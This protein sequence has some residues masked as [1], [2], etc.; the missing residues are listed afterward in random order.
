LNI[1]EAIEATAKKQKECRL[2]FA[3][4]LFL[5]ILFIIILPVGGGFSVGHLFENRLAPLFFIIIYIPF[6]LAAL[7]ANASRVTSELGDY[8]AFYKDVFARAAIRGTDSNFNY[9]PFAGISRKEFHKIG[10]YSPDEFHAED[11]I[12]GIY[13]GVKFS[14]SE[15][16]DI[17]NGA[18]LE[19]SDSAAL[20]LLSAIVFAWEAMKDMQ[21]FS[22]SV[23]VC[24]FYKKFSGQTI[25]A[26]RTLNTRFLGEKEQMDDLF[27]SKEFR[28]FADDKVEA[29][30]LLTP[31]FMA[32]L[33]DLKEKFA[34]KMGLSAAFMDNKLY[35]FLNGAK[36]KFETTLFSL[37]PSLEDAA[38]IK[39]EILELLSIIDELSL[40][41]DLSGA[42]ILAD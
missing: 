21:A 7:M 40:N 19:L 6:F 16:I 28:V 20:N 2:A 36:N 1:N 5:G 13:K 32:R 10:I 12:S 22:G 33:R 18:T 14:L 3:K 34:G 17:P 37:P 24:E 27:F 11:Q 9:D 42:A 23:L 31:A 38:E 26:S 25:A 29:R 4:Y 35:L 8:K 39:N 15:A 30:Y 41:H